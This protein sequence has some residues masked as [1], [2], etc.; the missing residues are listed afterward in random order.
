MTAQLHAGRTPSVSL[1]EAELA[2]FAA[3]DDLLIDHKQA[4]AL[5]SAFLQM[6]RE[7]T[8]SSGG[9]DSDGQ[10]SSGEKPAARLMSAYGQATNTL[11]KRCPEEIWLAYCHDL[12]ALGHGEEAIK[13]ARDGCA[14]LAEA[15]VAAGQLAIVLLQQALGARFA[16]ATF[17]FH[18]QVSIS[19][20]LYFGCRYVRECRLG[21]RGV[22]EMGP[23]H[24]F[25][26]L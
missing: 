8:F 16:R 2:A 23:Y 22:L 7:S 12:N 26:R 17:R 19:V 6:A 14:R 11:G 21:F 18:I 25:T 24:T 5:W 3:F 20:G 1:Q 13:V 4:V 15:R 9:D 10:V